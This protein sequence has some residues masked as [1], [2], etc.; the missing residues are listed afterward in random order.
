[1]GWSAI[2]APAAT[3]VHRRRIRPGNRRQVPAL[4]NRHSV[5]NRFLLRLKNQT[6]SNL[7]RTWLA[8]T[9]RDCAVI[10][11]VL[12]REWSSIPG[13]LE[14]LA[15]LGETYRKRRV[16]MARRRAADLD[17]DRWFADPAS[18]DLRS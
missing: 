7:R 17:V 16:I 4:I 8:G 9:L 6:P 13:L 10:G 3:A 18:F 2:Y 5:K 11:Y 15:R 14:V 1:M 12:L